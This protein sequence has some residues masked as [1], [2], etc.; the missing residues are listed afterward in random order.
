MAVTTTVIPDTAVTVAVSLWC[1]LNKSAIRAKAMVKYGKEVALSYASAEFY[2]ISDDYRIIC[3]LT[4]ELWAVVIIEA[5]TCVSIEW[6]TL[7]ALLLSVN[8][9][10]FLISNDLCNFVYV[11]FFFMAVIIILS[12][13]LI[14]WFISRISYAVWAK[15]S[16][17]W[18]DLII[19]NLINAL[20]FVDWIELK[21]CLTDTINRS[22]DFNASISRCWASAYSRFKLPTEWIY[23]TW[24]FIDRVIFSSSDAVIT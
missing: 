1:F 24:G 20:T 10:N 19:W 8:S 17:L 23:F 22:K 16:S 2:R 4:V 7:W 14:L 3:W 21:G 5:S 15:R 12:L 18:E 13:T 6:R 9:V 11:L